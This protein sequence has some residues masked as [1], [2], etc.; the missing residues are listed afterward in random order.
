MANCSVR[1]Q[2]RYTYDA[3]STILSLLSTGGSPAITKDNANG[4]I[5][6]VIPATTTAALVEGPAV[7]DVEVVMANA[8]IVRLVQG[9]FVISP[10]V[11]R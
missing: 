5:T 6:I 2:V 1:M 7:Y 11:T 3:A 4:V 9:Q 10:E 8:E